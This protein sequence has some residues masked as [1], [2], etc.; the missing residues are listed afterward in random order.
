MVMG[1]RVMAW[2]GDGRRS[3]RETQGSNSQNA[4][5]VGAEK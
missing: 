5:A 3:N 4:G 2:E 1:L